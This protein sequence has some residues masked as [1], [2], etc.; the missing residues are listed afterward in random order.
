MF[1]WLDYQLRGQTVLVQWVSKVE[2]DVHVRK[3]IL[4]AGSR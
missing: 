4:E 1:V 3:L 2:S